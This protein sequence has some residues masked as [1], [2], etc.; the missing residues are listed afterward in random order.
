MKPASSSFLISSQMKFCRSTNYFW[1]FYWTGLASGYIFRWCSITSLGISGICD[2]CQA[3]TSTLARRKVMTVSS[4]LLSKSPETQ[5]VCPASAPTWTIFT[6]TSSLTEGCT[7]GA[8]T[9]PCWCELVARG[10]GP[11]APR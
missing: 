6:G 5:V 9:E 4:Y 1:G 8:E 2:D 11:Q 3:N 7:Q 10:S